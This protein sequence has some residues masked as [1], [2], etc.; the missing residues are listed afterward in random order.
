MLFRDF[1]VLA[2]L[3]ADLVSGNHRI[4]AIGG[5]G[6]MFKHCSIWNRGDAPLIRTISHADIDRDAAADV[7]HLCHGKLLRLRPGPPPD[8]VSGEG[9]YQSSMGLVTIPAV[10]KKARRI[11]APTGHMIWNFILRSGSVSFQEPSWFPSWGSLGSARHF[12]TWP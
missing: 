6:D 5:G 10:A 9:G 8:I 7:F 11:V 3:P 4:S 2:G 12:H 1:T